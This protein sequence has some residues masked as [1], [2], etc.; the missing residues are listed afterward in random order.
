MPIE[1]CVH[2]ITK[3]TNKIKCVQDGFGFVTPRHISKI[4]LFFCE[5]KTYEKQKSHNKRL[6]ILE[7]SKDYSG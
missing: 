3:K 4:M 7:Q 6:N 1:G 5:G 2:F